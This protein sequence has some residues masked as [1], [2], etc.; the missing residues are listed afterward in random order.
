[1]P[2]G[3]RTTLPTGL[4]DDRGRATEAWLRPI[5]GADELLVQEHAAAGIIRG[6]VATL[7]LAACTTAI[8]ARAPVDPDLA[9]SLC[10]GDREALLLQ[11]RRLTFGDAIQAVLPCPVCGE[12]LDLDL[13]AGA[14]LLAPNPGAAAV[15]TVR[16]EAEGAAWRVTL[17]RVTGADQH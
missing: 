3:L 15:E 10:V 9:D 17:R 13:R 8:G 1:M 12:L 14:L 4:V 5:T 11:L 7:L 2:A 6:E 16:I